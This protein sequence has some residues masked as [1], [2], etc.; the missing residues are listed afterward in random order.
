MAG[1]SLARAHESPP[2]FKAMTTATRRCQGGVKDGDVAGPSPSL[3]RAHESHI[4][5]SANLYSNDHGYKK[6][7][8]YAHPKICQAFSPWRGRSCVS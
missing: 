1:P 5:P 8:Q 6:V 7:Y 2:T 3:A 4:R